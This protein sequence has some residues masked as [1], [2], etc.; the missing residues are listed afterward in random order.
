[1]FYL[2]FVCLSPFPW[3]FSSLKFPSMKHFL[4]FTYVNNPLFCTPLALS[5]IIHYFYN[6][7]SHDVLYT[8]R[9]NEKFD[10]SFSFASKATKK[11]L[12]KYLP[13][14]FYGLKS[15]SFNLSYGLYLNC[16]V[17]FKIKNLRL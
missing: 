9:E 13:M 5:H 2:L 1:M 16:L 15:K 8:L 14:N 6:N 7:F 10:S 4:T 11:S 17:I 12:Y 3:A